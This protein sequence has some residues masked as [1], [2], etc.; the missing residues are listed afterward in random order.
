M[1]P[2]RTR[3]R[4][5]RRCAR[6][7]DVFFGVSA[8]G[9]ADDRDGALDGAEPDHLR[10]GQSRPRDHA[11]GGARRSATTRS[12]RPAARTIRT[13]STTS[14]ASPTSSRRARRARDA[15]QRRDE[16]RGG[17]SAGRARARGRAR[18][19]RFGYKG[20]GRPKFG[21]DYIIPAPSTRLIT[22][23]RKPWP[24]RDGIG[25][26]AQG[27]RGLDRLSQPAR[28]APRSDRRHLP[29]H[30]R[31][32]PPAARARSSSRKGRRSR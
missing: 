2:T 3:A 7:V 24:R 6:R 11:G 26:R 30:L 17:R 13:R 10:H 8:K 27:H 31:H 25:R 1:P 4:W 18:C 14:S 19:R 32:A 15:D 20:S 16:D 5:R 29:E 12:W 21:R 28:L 9:R 22:H 23:I